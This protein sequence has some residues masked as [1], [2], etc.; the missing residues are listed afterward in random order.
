MG[1]GDDYRPV[2]RKQ[3]EENYERAFPKTANNACNDK[4]RPSNANDGK[5]V[6]SSQER[7]E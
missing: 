5:D 7:P 4:T 6:P 2:N 3:Y 1:K